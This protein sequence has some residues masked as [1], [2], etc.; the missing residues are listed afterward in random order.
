MLGPLGEWMIC[1]TPTPGPLVM[2]VTAANA[3][4]PRRESPRTACASPAT[5]TGS[6]EIFPVE[7]VISILPLT[8]CGETFA[9]AIEEDSG[10]EPIGSGPAQYHAVDAV[11]PCEHVETEER[12]TS[13]GL[14]STNDPM[15]NEGVP[16]T[17][18]RA[19]A[20]REHRSPR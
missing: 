15:S 6:E 19:N 17:P 20:A 8:E 3:A 9:I 2:T 13:A 16:P 12:L 10:R 7:L 18:A 1:D 11:A 4:F 5:A 14:A